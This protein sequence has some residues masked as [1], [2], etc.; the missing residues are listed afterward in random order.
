M[1][2]LDIRR[3]KHAAKAKTLW[4]RSVVN[5]AGDA[6]RDGGDDC[7]PTSQ[8][9]LGQAPV[10][11]SARED[12]SGG[13]H[14]P[15][16][17]NFDPLVYRLQHQ[18]KYR[19]EHRDGSERDPF[20]VDESCSSETTP[21][22]G[23]CEADGDVDVV[24]W[25][26]GSSPHCSLSEDVDDDREEAS[27]LYVDFG[28]V[29][30]RPQQHHSTAAAHRR[31]DDGG[32][33]G[34]WLSFGQAATPRVSGDSPTP[35]VEGGAGSDDDDEDDDDG[36]PSRPSQSDLAHILSSLE[37]ESSVQH[38]QLVPVLCAVDVGRS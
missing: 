13:D 29:T 22:R 18:K 31:G 19:R 37:K 27:A 1:F 4:F 35:R 7:R 23:A 5:V 34:R 9:R 25:G 3:A 11:H 2:N 38:P 12:A 15:Q 26:R 10:R 16:G 8:P 36:A 17:Q 24:G 14:D 32:P 20:D 30:P 28:G 21:S 33:T 6:R